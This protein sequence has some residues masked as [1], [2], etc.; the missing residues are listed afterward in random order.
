MAGRLPSPP[1]TYDRRWASDFVRVLDFALDELSQPIAVGYRAL[2][3]SPHRALDAGDG[4]S[5]RGEVGLVQVVVGGAGDC[6]VPVSGV[7]GNGTYPDNGQ[8][9]LV[10]ATLIS[11]ARARGIL[12]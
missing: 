2:L 3:A 5:A 9:A 10:L 6:R 11:D 4:T 7:G 1:P 8:I 12:G